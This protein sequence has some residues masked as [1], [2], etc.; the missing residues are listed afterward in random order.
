VLRGIFLK[1]SGEELK[2]Y[3]LLKLAKGKIMGCGSLQSQR[4]Q[5]PLVPTTAAQPVTLPLD[6]KENPNILT[7][8][9]CY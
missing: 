2:S 6:R 5:A 1:L 9:K 3:K 4:C 8:L 7:K